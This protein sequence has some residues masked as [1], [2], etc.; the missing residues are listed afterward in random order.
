MPPNSFH[1]GG[2]N[3]LRADGSVSFISETIDTGNLSA[4]SVTSGISPYGTWGALGSK[5][6]GEVVSE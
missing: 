1:P 4:A 2:V 3:A 6:G 5:N